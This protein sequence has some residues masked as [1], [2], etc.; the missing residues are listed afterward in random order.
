MLRFQ[1]LPIIQFYKL[2]FHRNCLKLVIYQQLFLLPL[3]LR[4]DPFIDALDMLNSWLIF[5]FYFPEYYD[6][7]IKYLPKR[8]I[9][10]KSW[11]CPQSLNRNS[12]RLFVI[13]M[14][15]YP[16]NCIL[17]KCPLN[18]LDYIFLLNLL[19]LPQFN[20][21]YP[22]FLPFYYFFL[23]IYFFLTTLLNFPLTLLLI[24]PLLQ[25]FIFLLLL[26]LKLLPIFLL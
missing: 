8:L 10:K 17:L 12:I 9:L 21:Y 5:Q 6:L 19:Q 26:I 25:V 2:H 7:I 15:I 14:I 20:L 4:M 1:I 22:Y 24:F 23:M 13:R 11:I 16:R 18:L 3:S